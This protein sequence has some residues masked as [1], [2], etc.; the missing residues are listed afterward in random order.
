MTSKKLLA[1]GEI[2]ISPMFMHGAR[3]KEEFVD[4]YGLELGTF[5]RLGR[6]LYYNIKTNDDLL[7]RLDWSTY[8]GN[9][10]FKLKPYQKTFDLTVTIWEGR[11][12][13]GSRESVRVRLFYND[14]PLKLANYFSK[15]IDTK[16]KYLLEDIFEAEQEEKKRRRLKEIENSLL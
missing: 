8:Q 4:K 7:K 5:D 2:N 9:L 11:L 16:F 13:D 3:F 1:L 14:L 10:D 6:S 15:E 12:L